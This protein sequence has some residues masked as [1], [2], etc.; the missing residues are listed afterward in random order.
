[1]SER[2]FLPTEVSAK[3]IYIDPLGQ[4]ASSNSK[5]E[6]KRL[7]RASIREL[8]GKPFQAVMRA[9]NWIE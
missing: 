6:L 4:V 5:V 8:F 9:T 1:M 7:S 2:L 3:L